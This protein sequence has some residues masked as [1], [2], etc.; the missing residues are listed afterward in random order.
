M[1]KICCCHSLGHSFCKEERLARKCA[2]RRTGLWALAHQGGQESPSGQPFQANLAILVALL[3]LGFLASLE[4]RSCL[5]DLLA[6]QA[7]PHPLFLEGQLRLEALKVLA[8]PFLH[9][10]L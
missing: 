9:D 3:F 7:L 1:G 10:G 2:R 6:L 4:F 5:E 8:V